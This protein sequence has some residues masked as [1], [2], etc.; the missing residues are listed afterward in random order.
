MVRRL[1]NKEIRKRTAN[2]AG[3]GDILMEN[4]VSGGIKEASILAPG[5][6]ARGNACKRERLQGG[7]PARGNACKMLCTGYIA[8]HKA[9]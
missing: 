9:S 8:G 3:H 4:L 6:P 7:T 1:V 5:T 2:Q